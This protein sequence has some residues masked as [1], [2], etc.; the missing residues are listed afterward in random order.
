MAAP[1]IVEQ[2]QTAGGALRRGTIIAIDA[3]GR[4]SVRGPGEGCVVRCDALESGLGVAPYALGDSVVF[5]SYAHS[6]SEGCVLGRI[7]AT[8]PVDRRTL[9]LPA[10]ELDVDE[11]IVSA[12]RR[13]V[14]GTEN[15]SLRIA[16]DKVET[17]AFTIVSKARRLQK[18][19]AP[20]IRLN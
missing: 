10:L 16:A 11:L 20:M 19:L 4:L 18:L 1:N 14:L 6:D 13:I 2:W 7:G 17:I 12:K 3:Q 5:A 15:A 9:R 8:A